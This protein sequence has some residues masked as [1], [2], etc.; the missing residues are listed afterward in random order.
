MLWQNQDYD[1]EIYVSVT[2]KPVYLS[3]PLST[4]P[5]SYPFSAH[6]QPETSSPLASLLQHGRCDATMAFCS[7]MSA[8]LWG[9]DSLDSYNL[10][11]TLE[12]L[13]S[14]TVQSFIILSLWCLLTAPR[15]WWARLWPW[16][17]IAT[18][19]EHYPQQPQISLGRGCPGEAHS[20][21]PQEAP[22]FLLHP[23]ASA[24]AWELYVGQA[25]TRLSS[26][27]QRGSPSQ[28]NP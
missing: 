25:E 12:T 17:D 3:T 19:T 20:L 4:L 26:L 7:S 5:A 28:E 22:R 23:R 9:V 16:A 10:S 21:S 15:L 1:P 8:P 18:G 6:T 14:G 24:Q 11:C 27:E 2:S 13:P